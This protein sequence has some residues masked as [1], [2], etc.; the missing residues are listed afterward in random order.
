MSRA[1][2]EQVHIIEKAAVPFVFPLRCECETA[3][4]LSI[5]FVPCWGELGPASVAQWAGRQNERR[6]WGQSGPR[7]GAFGELRLGLVFINH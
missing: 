6:S 7:V 4:L 5:P 1:G 3:E 2:F